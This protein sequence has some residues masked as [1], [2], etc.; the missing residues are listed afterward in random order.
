[1]QWLEKGHWFAFPFLFWLLYQFRAG[2]LIAIF[3]LILP[4][5]PKS[6]ASP[7]DWF[8]TSDQKAQKL[9][10]DGNWQEAQDV[11]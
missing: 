9:A 4:Q 10:D 11:I 2:V 3:C 1:M 5:A 6:Y 8:S 7:L